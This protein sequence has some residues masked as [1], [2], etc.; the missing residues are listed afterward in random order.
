MTISDW[1]KAFKQLKAK[2]AKMKKYIK[3]NAPKK[4]ST[5]I[6]RF[7]CSRC[8]R[9]GSRVSKYGLQLCR[10]CFREIASKIGFRK[11]E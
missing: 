4:R 9:Y 3:H 5:G 8:G 1:K 11:Y 6:S 10:T 7:P 2:P